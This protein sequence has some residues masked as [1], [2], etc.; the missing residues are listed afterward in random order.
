MFEARMRA[1]QAEFHITKAVF[2]ASRTRF[3]GCKAAL[4]ATKSLL[5][6]Q[7]KTD[8]TCAAHNRHTVPLSS[9]SQLFQGNNELFFIVFTFIRWSL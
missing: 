2:K 5:S 3:L 9:P 4:R 8:D 6:F 7:E 1:N